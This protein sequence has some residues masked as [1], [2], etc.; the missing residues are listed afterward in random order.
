M[1]SSDSNEN[2]SPNE[3]DPIEREEQLTYAEAAELAF[4]LHAAGRLDE[5]ERL[6]ATLQKANPDDV[7][8]L[9]YLGVL[10]HQQGRPTEALKLI[11]RSLAADDT[12]A[13]W[14]NNYGNVLLDTDRF[15]E[16]A[17]AYR[18]CIELDPAN[19]EV[20][21]NLGV[22]YRHQQ[23]FEAAREML[24]RALD[25]QPD[26]VGAHLNLASVYWAMGRLDEAHTQTI[27][28]LQLYPRDT[29]IRKMLGSL[30]GR[31]GRLE[32]AAD[33]YREWLALEP[34]SLDARHHLAGCTGVD[35][36]ERAGD[37]YVEGL[38]DR[39][40][41]SFDAKL[42]S[43]E[44][45]APQIIGDALQRVLPPPQR[46]LRILDA[47]CGTGLCGKLLAPYARELLGV[48]LSANMI[49]R[50]LARGVYDSIVRSE[51]VAHMESVEEPFDLIVSADTLCYFGR[52]ESVARAAR[53]ALRAGGLLLFTVEAHPGG[54]DYRL[55]PHGRYSHRND[56]LR[57]TLEAAG[58]RVRE[59]TDVTLRFEAGVPVEGLLVI[60][61]AV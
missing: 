13:A 18:R 51:L 20:L 14:H 2:R 59:L 24:Q 47:G 26:F 28:A 39:F 35:V 27:D 55:H 48:D 29:R 34:D 33:V 37:A 60:G 50:A 16:A 5:S 4:R 45:R 43:L 40:A 46:D 6:Y 36:P 12:V 30:Y 8:V 54:D 10:T 44:Y 42:A 53:H 9:H 49:E 11:E 52:L 17:A 32:D 41:E 23:Q 3:A 22:M 21:C 19:V 25:A 61:Q 58:L 7:N 31:L 56:Y 1:T 57:T 38:F 15:D